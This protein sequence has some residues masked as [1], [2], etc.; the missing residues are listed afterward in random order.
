MQHLLCKVTIVNKGISVICP[1]TKPLAWASGREN[2]Y[3]KWRC[4]YEKSK[5]TLGGSYGYGYVAFRRMH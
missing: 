3:Q 5:K 4:K 1:Y 2:A